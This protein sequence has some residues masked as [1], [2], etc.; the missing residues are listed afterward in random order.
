MSASDIRTAPLLAEAWHRAR[1][2]QIVGPRHA[3]PQAGAVRG[4]GP[5]AS[6]EFDHACARCRRNARSGRRNRCFDRTKE[7]GSASIRAC[8]GG[9]SLDTVTCPIGGETENASHGTIS[10]EH[11]QPMPMLARQASSSQHPFLTRLRLIPSPLRPSTLQA[12]GAESLFQS[13]TV[14]SRHPHRRFLTSP[15]QSRLLHPDA[16]NGAQSQFTATRRC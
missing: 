14:L 16:A 15:L 12:R 7:H 1:R 3:R 9:R 2:G 6:G 5:A 4:S 10:A 8:R 11:F 13:T